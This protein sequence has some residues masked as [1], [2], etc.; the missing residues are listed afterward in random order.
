MEKAIETLHKQRKDYEAKL[1]KGHEVKDIYIQLHIYIHTH[2]YSININ[3]DLYVYT[4]TYTRPSS[5]RG[6]M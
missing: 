5:R 3:I 2:I 4:Y 1:E 6:T